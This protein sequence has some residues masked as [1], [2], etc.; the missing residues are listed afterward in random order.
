MENDGKHMTECARSAVMLDGEISSYVDTLRGVA[1]GCALSQSVFEVYVSDL[2][3]AVEAAKQG[4]TV[5]QDTPSGSMFADDFVGI[6][7]TPEGF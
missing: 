4:V 6:A 1:Q 5:G 3:V 2:I 7:E